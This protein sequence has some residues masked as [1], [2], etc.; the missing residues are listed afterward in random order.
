[1]LALKNRF[2]LLEAAQK[3]H[4]ENFSMIIVDGF[5]GEE[6]AI[7]YDNKFNGEIIDTK[8]F[9]KKFNKVFPFKVRV[10]FQS[11]TYNCMI[12]DSDGS[13]LSIKPI[14]SCLP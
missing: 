3:I 11:D 6:V 12:F 5:T 9:E 14:K 1:M 2:I 7:W 4:W 10:P 8:P 13:N